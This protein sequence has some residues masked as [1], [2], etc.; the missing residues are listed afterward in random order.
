M[1]ALYQEVNAAYKV[2]VH[3]DGQVKWPLSESARADKALVNSSGWIEVGSRARFD[4]SS[5]DKM[6]KE[7]TLILDVVNGTL[8][9]TTGSSI[10]AE[11]RK[12]AI[13]STVYYSGDNIVDAR[14]WSQ[15]EDLLASKGNY[16]GSIYYYRRATQL[17]PA[18][19]DSH[20]NMGVTLSRLGKYQDAVK[21]YESA[22]ALNY[23]YPQ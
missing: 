3:D 23:L 6:D 2:E 11:E 4:P 19:A 17:G 16:S 5:R 15:C 14:T 18:S 1:S 21:A 7:L 10:S 20:N 13:N 12:R 22:V 9:N 8:K